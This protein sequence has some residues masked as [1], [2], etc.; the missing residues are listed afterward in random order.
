MWRSSRRLVEAM[1]AGTSMIARYCRLVRRCGKKKTIVAVGR[2]LLVTIWHLLCDPE[3]RFKDLGAD[4]YDCHVKT[5]A[6]RR[7]HVRELEALG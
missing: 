5:P 6:E 4:H 3:A 7:S 2:S 1:R